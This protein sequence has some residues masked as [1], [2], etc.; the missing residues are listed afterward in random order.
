[1]KLWPRV[2]CLVFLTQC[3]QVASASAG[4]AELCWRGDACIRAA[5]T[6]R[7]VRWWCWTHVQRGRF[8]Q[9]DDGV[10]LTLDDD[11]DEREWRVGRLAVSSAPAVTAPSVAR[12]PAADA[13][14]D[15]D[16]LRAR[17][18]SVF[19]TA[20]SHRVHT[21]HISA[22]LY[23]LLY[24]H[25]LQLQK[26]EI[27]KAKEKETHKREREFIFHIAKTLE[28]VHNKNAKLGGLPER[29]LAHQSWPPITCQRAQRV[30]CILTMQSGSAR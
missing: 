7:A 18:S 9:W 22:A 16:R 2:W 19:T 5:W 25:K 30:K 28:Q 11:D 6:Y 24:S 29:H 21:L 14:A 4:T 27:K 1:V 10:E 15:V 8:V 17:D 20:Q 13:D 12:R 3:R 26:Q 23:I